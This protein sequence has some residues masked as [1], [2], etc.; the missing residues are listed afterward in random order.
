MER[1]YI[2]L[3]APAGPGSDPST[4]EQLKQIQD[5]VNWDRYLSLIQGRAAFGPIKF[6]G[7][8]MTA[9]ITDAKGAHGFDYRGW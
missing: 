4:A 9:N 8:M 1:S 3:S 5:H 7:Q 2:E 6:N